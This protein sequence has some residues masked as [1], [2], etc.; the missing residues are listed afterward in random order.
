MSAKADGLDKYLSTQ[1]FFKSRGVSQLKVRTGCQA[2]K[3][4]KIV[5]V[6]DRQKELPG[7]RKVQKSA[8]KPKEIRR[9]QKVQKKRK[10]GRSYC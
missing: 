2:F 9:V 7:A 4:K 1:V 6:K 5:Q 10:A 8:K 3:Q